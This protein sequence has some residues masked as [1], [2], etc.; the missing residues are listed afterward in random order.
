MSNI[1]DNG[2]WITEG[3]RYNNE[4]TF[5]EKFIVSELIWHCEKSLEGAST[6]PNKRWE[7]AYGISEQGV[8]GIISSLIRKGFV[9]KN[10]Q[11]S[12]TDGV[13]RTTRLLQITNKTLDLLIWK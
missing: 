7:E 12:E 1:R 11:K 3:I 10:L 9:V 5:A 4:L 6:A 8:I 2:V 13:W